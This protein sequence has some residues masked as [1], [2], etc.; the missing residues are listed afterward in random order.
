M[1]TIVMISFWIWLGIEIEKSEI[2][3]ERLE[4]F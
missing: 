3:D 2:V 1:I 4:Y